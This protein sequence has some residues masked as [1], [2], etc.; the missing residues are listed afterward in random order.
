MKKKIIAGVVAASLMASTALAHT[1]SIGYV[2]DGSG[3]LNFWYGN[4]HGMAF[5][6]A[7]IKI[8]GKVYYKAN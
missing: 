1:N 3:G 7:E 6:E 4:W 2:G 5:N 8:I